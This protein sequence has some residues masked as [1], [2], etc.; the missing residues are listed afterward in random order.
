MRRNEKTISEMKKQGRRKIRLDSSECGKDKDKDKDSTI[1]TEVK[2]NTSK[3]WS[4]KKKRTI[5]APK[6]RHGSTKENISVFIWP[7]IYFSMLFCLKSV[8]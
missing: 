2:S 4:S 3:G 6:Q 8:Q 5:F 7:L 1:L